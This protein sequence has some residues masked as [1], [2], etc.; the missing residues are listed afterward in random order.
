MWIISFIFLWTTPTGSGA[1]DGL[2]CCLG[3]HLTGHME[4]LG[5]YLKS[6]SYSANSDNQCHDEIISLVSYHCK[7]HEGLLIYRKIFAS[8]LFGEF[9][10]VAML[11]CFM[12]F[13][14]VTVKILMRLKKSEIRLIDSQFILLVRQ[15][16]CESAM[17]SFCDFRFISIISLRFCRFSNN[18]QG[19]L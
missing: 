4:I 6:V 8:S 1:H 7:I 13:Q 16:D 14:V 12:G 3:I 11:T 18:Q 15:H 10:Y 2:I 17:C 19:D 5:N 9:A